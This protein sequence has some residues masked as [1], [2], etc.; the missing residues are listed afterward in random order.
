MPEF[1]MPHPIVILLARRRRALGLTQTE[2]ARRIGTS[3][4]AISDMELG[5]ASPTLRTLGRYASAVGLMLVL[6]EDM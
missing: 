1:P 4:S 6:A 2:L 3:Q 5:T